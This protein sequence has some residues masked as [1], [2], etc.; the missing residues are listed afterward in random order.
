MD[1]KYILIRI[2]Q[3]FFVWASIKYSHE[4]SKWYYLDDRYSKI[5]KGEKKVSEAATKFENFWYL[6]KYIGVVLIVSS[7][8]FQFSDN[9]FIIVGI[10]LLLSSLF[11]LFEAIEEDLKLDPNERAKKVREKIKTNKEIENYPH[12]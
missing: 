10:T 12:Y 6:L 1:I 2:A 4:F 3:I 8:A 7:P 11:G 9:D 5:I